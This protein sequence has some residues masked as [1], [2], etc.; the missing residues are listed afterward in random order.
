MV[1]AQALQ[2]FFAVCV[3][4]PT[5]GEQHLRCV[6]A[7]LKR[8]LWNDSEIDSQIIRNLSPRLS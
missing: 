3:I 6:D 8:K 4:K 7:I 2:A 5:T 1:L